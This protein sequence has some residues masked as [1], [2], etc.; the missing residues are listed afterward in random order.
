MKLDKIVVNGKISFG[1]YIFFINP[2]LFI[3][4]LED[5]FIDIAQ[6]EKGNKPLNKNIT[7]CFSSKRITYENTIEVTVIV[8]NG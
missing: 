7:N 2:S 3:I 1:T 4:E 8:N 5:R 6:N